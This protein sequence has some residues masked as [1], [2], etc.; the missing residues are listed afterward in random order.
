LKTSVCMLSER[1]E[2]K[3]AVIDSNL[4]LSVIAAI[5]LFILASL[6]LQARTVQIM[7]GDKLKLKSM[8]ENAPVPYAI[9]G[10]RW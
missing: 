3:T 1:H 6:N 5:S 4:F 7:S 8:F 2:Y 9:L 10:Q